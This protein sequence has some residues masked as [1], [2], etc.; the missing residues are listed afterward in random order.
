MRLSAQNCFFFVRKNLLHVVMMK[1]VID[2][3][4]L[5]FWPFENEWKFRRKMLQ[6]I[7]NSAKSE[8]Q[9]Q[10][11]HL[12]LNPGMYEC[13]IIIQVTMR[14][15]DSPLLIPAASSSIVVNFNLFLNWTIR[16]ICFM[17]SLSPMRKLFLFR[18]LLNYYF[19]APCLQ[20]IIIT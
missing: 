5:A 10:L 18:T 20:I 3:G 12:L 9:Q 13:I 2:W 8:Y 19:I 11:V 14:I 1:K 6:K 7:W 15:T 16:F 17:T 4:F